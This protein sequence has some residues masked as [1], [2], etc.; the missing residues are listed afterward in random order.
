MAPQTIKTLLIILILFSSTVVGQEIKKKEL[1]P[2]TKSAL[3]PGW[4]QKSLNHT[5]R[6]RTFTYIESGLL[7][8]I[9]GTTT[10]SNII[11]KNYIAFASEHAAVSSAGKDHKY[12]VDIGNFDT[13]TDYNDEH[14]RNREIDDLYLEDKKWSWDW[15]TDANR[16]AFEKKRILSDQMKWAATF[17]AGAVVLNHMVSA[18]D[19][20][21][22]KR[23]MKNKKLS[24]QPWYHSESG[25]MGYALIIHF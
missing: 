8:T 3:V 11:K 22:L 12:W 13:I 18:I 21:Y 25:N 14:L 7:V 20:A 1:D 9:L 19:A 5:K 6:G 24:V 15:D 16:D 2:V 17:S 10:F 23:V 4:G